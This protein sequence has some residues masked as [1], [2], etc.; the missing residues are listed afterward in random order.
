MDI[1]P[2]NSKWAQWNTPVYTIFSKYSLPAAKTD[3]WSLIARWFWVTV[4]TMTLDDVFLDS[5]YHLHTNNAHWHLHLTTIFEKW[6]K[7][8]LQLNLWQWGYTVSH[9]V[10]RYA[11][12]DGIFQI[13]LSNPIEQASTSS[14]Q[15]P[16]P[17]KHFWFHSY[18]GLKF[19]RRKFE[20][21][22][23]S[24][25]EREMGY[26]KVWDLLPRSTCVP[27][28]TNF[29]SRSNRRCVRAETD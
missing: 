4:V 7:V 13:F 24:I 9:S 8:S 22:A 21:R 12:R 2:G 23:L 25:G 27:W 10:N 5:S 3:V 1:Y 20:F 26:G 15:R 11:S 18:N 19:V 6:L 16:V 28:N 14:Y 29:D 17:P